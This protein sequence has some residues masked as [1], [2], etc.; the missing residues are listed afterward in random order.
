MIERLGEWIADAPR[1][2]VPGA[3][4]SSRELISAILNPRVE[5]APMT[6]PEAPEFRDGQ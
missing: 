2:S 5:N 6:T 3:L 4:G 1:Q